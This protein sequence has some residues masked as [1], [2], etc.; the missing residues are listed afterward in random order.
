MLD[1]LA[2][3]VGLV[4]ADILSVVSMAVVVT[5]QYEDSRDGFLRVFGWARKLVSGAWGNFSV[6]WD[7]VFHTEW[8]QTLRRWEEACAREDADYVRRGGSRKERMAQLASRATE[9]TKLLGFT[10]GSVVM[11]CLSS[12]VLAVASVV[13][14]SFKYQIAREVFTGSQA[15]KAW[16]LYFLGWSVELTMVNMVS[17]GVVVMEAGFGFLISFTLEKLGQVN[18]GEL[19]T[20]AWWYITLLSISVLAA[21]SLVGV[22]VWIGTF[23]GQLEVD[24]T[25]L[26][27]ASQHKSVGWAVVASVGMSLL[28]I[29]M[30]AA[31]E[32]TVSQLKGPLTIILRGCMALVGAVINGSILL[33]A[34]ALSGLTFLLGGQAVFGLSMLENASSDGDKM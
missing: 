30:A 9:K 27:E 10:V 22:E 13:G 25:I 24:P 26:D 31:W 5:L 14:Y 21:L 1:F 19:R 32:L 6:L 7:W 28:T 29:S 17:M 4:V 2:W 33:V 11:F 20:S 8:M 15:V 23:R 34:A 18:R 16:E 3:V 12:I